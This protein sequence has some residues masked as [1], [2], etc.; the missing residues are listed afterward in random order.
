MQLGITV[1]KESPNFDSIV[2]NYLFVNDFS[3]KPDTRQ[4]SDQ[5]F[6]KYPIK[7]N[8]V[9]FPIHMEV[10]DSNKELPAI[11]GD[12]DAIYY[13]NYG[14]TEFHKGNY[15]K[16][17]NLWLTCRQKFGKSYPHH[18]RNDYHIALAFMMIAKKNLDA[19]MKFD[20]AKVRGNLANAAT[21]LSWALVVKADT[22][23]EVIE[24][25]SPKQFYNLA[26]IY[27]RYARFAGAYGAAERGL[28][29]LAK[30][31]R[32][33]FRPDLR[34][35]LAESHIT[36]RTYLE[37]VKQLDTAIRQDPDPKQAAAMFSRVGDIYF[38]LNNYE[39]AEYAYDLANRVDRDVSQV[40]PSQFIL[41]GE[42]LFWMG[43]FD[44]AQKNFN[45]ALERAA[46][47]AVI[48]NLPAD[49]A[50]KAHLRIADS[51]LAQNKYDAAKLEYFR[52]S[53]EYRGTLESEIAKIRSA[54]LELPHFDGN[55]VEHARKLLS[56]LK[57]RENLPYEAN[58]LSWAC[59]V[60]SY[61]QRERTAAM[62]SRV[63]EFYNRYPESRFLASLVE[64][65]REVK[66][67]H[68]DQLFSEKK[69]YS[70]ISYF[71]KTRDLLFKD[72]NPPRKARLFE[73]Y[74]DTFHSDKAAE[75]WPD[76]NRSVPDSDLKKLRSAT[77]HAEIAAISRQKK[78]QEAN[79]KF[80]GALVKHTWSI[81]PSKQSRQYLYRAVSA[82]S[83]EKSKNSHL[84]WA[85][86]LVKDWAAKDKTT[87]CS[88]VYP[89]LAKM[90][91]DFNEHDTPFEILKKDTLGIV[92]NLLP[93]LLVQDETCAISLLELEFVVLKAS[94]SELG[95][96]YLGRGDWRITKALATLFWE[97]AEQNSV[98][99]QPTIAREIWS[100]IRDKAPSD[101]PEVA[102]AKVR[103]DPSQTEFE[104]IWR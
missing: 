37:A 55:N 79:Q 63:Q 92:D 18:R 91:H 94:P 69:T 57:S 80:G 102:F 64:P 76:Y 44:E 103:L 93:N 19:G 17:K 47:K 101:A 1:R 77:F 26:A 87:Y 62:V 73:A 58:E 86:R 74:V 39:L 40:N 7:L 71:E 38:D 52:V 6:W 96:R 75:F 46:D 95:R 100:L 78:W 27:Y 68:L 30:V 84:D 28:D 50:A 61:S 51:Y 4:I 14:R 24:E 2:K 49:Y 11:T 88:D 45:Y 98:N 43:R 89:V 66:A 67:S 48:S 13:M 59:E 72:L 32:K 81:T 65:V 90:V 54:C 53:N 8:T 15:E 42:A 5:L 36:N 82:K 83:D 31:G 97:V 23:D 41:R 16:A 99:G 20:D 25:I 35:I 60:A 34:R 33:D 22:Q 104:K 85:Y 70:A 21:F 12:G 29:F 10:Q 9:Y 56:E 3:Q